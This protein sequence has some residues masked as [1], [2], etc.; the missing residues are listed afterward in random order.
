MCLPRDDCSS[1]PLFNF[2]SQNC[3]FTNFQHLQFSFLYFLFASECDNAYYAFL[4]KSINVASFHSH[5][6][7][8]LP[9]KLDIFYTDK[10]PHST[11]I[12]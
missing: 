10:Y 6:C 11:L 2:I 12:R 1:S 7:Q 9:F 8:F 4:P 5:C 3:N